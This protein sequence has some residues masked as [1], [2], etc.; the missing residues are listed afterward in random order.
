MSEL[1]TLTIDTLGSHGEGV[2]HPDG[3]TIFVEGALPGERV[4]ARIEQR[5]KR[6]ARA[7]LLSIIE[8]SPNRVAAPCKLF[9]KCGGCQLMHLSYDQQL[10]VK[11]QRVSDALLRIGKLSGIDVPA[12]IP[13]PLSL[14]YRNKIQLPV[15]NSAQGLALGL[16]ARA[17]HDLVEVQSCPIHCALG[18]AAYTPISKLIKASGIPAYQAETNT[19]LLRHLLIKSAVHTGQILVILVTQNDAVHQTAPLARQIMTHCPAVKGVVQNIQPKNANT[20]LGKRSLLLAGQDWIEETLGYLRFKVSPA[21]FFQVNPQQ[22]VQLYSQ[23][24]SYADLQGHETVLDAYCGV[25]TLSLFFAR[26]AKNVIGVECVPEAIVD[27]KHNA[28]LNRIQNASFQCANAENYITRLKAI[29]VALLNPPRKGCDP[30]FLKELERLKPKKLIYISC[31]PGSL[32]RDLSILTS[33]SFHL[34]AIQPFDMFPQTAHVEC[35]AKL[36]LK[37]N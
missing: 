15:K 13:S 5:Q 33:G 2:G 23:A 3:F 6:Y 34:E 18:D 8:S 11:Q 32:A 9:G 4:K 19:G 12:C 26:H 17:S 22:A 35:V 28:S 37:T 24:L 21:S 31:D 27:A 20:I 16:Y 36:S 7:E 30:A 14:S 1:I 25:G 29:D 10:K